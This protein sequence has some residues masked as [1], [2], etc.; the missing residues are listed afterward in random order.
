MM[1]DVAH[2]INRIRREVGTRSLE[3]GQ[4]R[5]STLS[6][7]YDTDPGDLWDA[8]TNAE[9]IPRW[10]M[11]VSG[12]LRVGGRYQLEGNA[13]GVVERC[14]PPRSFAA[15]WEYGDQ[16]SWIEVRIEPAGD[17]KARFRLE[18]IAPVDDELWEQF[19]PGATGVGWDLGLL[20]LALHLASQE[21]VDPAAVAEW[22]QSE[23]GKEYVRLS[24]RAWCDASVA[25]GTDPAGAEAAAERTTAFYTE[26]P[27]A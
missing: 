18:H 14:D 16:V 21:A 5:V 12:D 17:G 3:E 7:V 11:P 4:A 1:I 23:E 15:T 26:E 6:Q 13:G 8:C 22:M 20:G 27:V 19:G 24:S 10:F 9:R 2:H 25:A